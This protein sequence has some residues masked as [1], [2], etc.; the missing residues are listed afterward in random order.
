[1]DSK[2]VFVVHSNECFLLKMQQTP[3]DAGM[4]P[5]VRIA[6][7]LRFDHAIELEWVDPSIHK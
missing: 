6:K 2:H 7:R 1:M 3:S 5:K 4:M